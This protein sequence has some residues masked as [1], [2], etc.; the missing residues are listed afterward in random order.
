[1]STIEEVDLESL[2]QVSTDS[3]REMPS[4]KFRC[5]WQEL[6]LFGTVSS[7]GLSI[8]VYKNGDILIKF[9]NVD[10]QWRKGMIDTKYGPADRNDFFIGSK[11]LVFK[12]HLTICSCPYEVCRET[13]ALGDALR[14]R[15]AWLRS[16]IESVRAVPVVPL[17]KSNLIIENQMRLTSSGKSNLRLL[18]IENNKLVEQL[19]SL[20]MAHLV[21]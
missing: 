2:E 10:G 16:K 1:M 4:S 21:Q 7:F 18:T 5:E 13:E 14:E 9:D 15:Q 3:Y 17:R 12:R 8:K 11:I 20:G 19:C 6:G